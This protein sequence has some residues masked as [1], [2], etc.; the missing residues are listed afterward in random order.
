M[1]GRMKTVA[2][3]LTEAA[4]LCE[5][6]WCQDAFAMDSDGQEVSSGDPSACRFCAHGAVNRASN[7]WP[8]AHEAISCL[9]YLL[10]E[11][12]LPEVVMTWNDDE[13]RTQAEVVAKL[14]EAAAL[15]AQEGM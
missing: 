9:A 5:R 10:K 2:E 4:D 7:A 11:S 15:A 8:V 12:S 6:G 1:E 13:A 3:V 14:R